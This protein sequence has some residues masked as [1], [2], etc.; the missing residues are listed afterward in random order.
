MRQQILGQRPHLHVHGGMMQD[1]S[2]Q[3]DGKKFVR[4]RRDGGGM[5][6]EMVK[7]H[8]ASADFGNH[9]V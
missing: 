9:A 6:S 2:L 4:N 1:M 8:R 3:H 5:V 7:T